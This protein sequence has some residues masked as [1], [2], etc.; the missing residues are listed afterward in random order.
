[1]WLNVWILTYNWL[2]SNCGTEPYCHSTK[3]F[4]FKSFHHSRVL[5]SLF[6]PGNSGG[7]VQDIL[8]KPDAKPYALHTTRW[9]PILMQ[10]DVQNELNRMESLRVI[11]HIDKAITMVY[12]HCGGAKAF[13]ES[14]NLCRHETLEWICYEREFHPLPAVVKTLAQL[15]QTHKLL[16]KWMQM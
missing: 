11:S 6:G 15:F 4:K 7:W 10:K 12:W 5:T 16:L 13:R 9:V 1:M 3:H 14:N 2:A 8:L